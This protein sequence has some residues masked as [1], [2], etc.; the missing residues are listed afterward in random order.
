MR[1][2]VAAA[3]E[4]CGVGVGV[5]VGEAGFWVGGGGG[6]DGG[7]G[8]EDMVRICGVDSVHKR[9]YEKEVFCVGLEDLYIKWLV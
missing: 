5:G 3:G 7:D 2:G 1:R 4:V 8:S 6:A 9:W